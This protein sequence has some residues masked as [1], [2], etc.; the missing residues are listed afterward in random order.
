[1]LLVRPF[2]TSL[3]SQTARDVL[4]VRVVT[5]EAEGWGE[6]VALTDPVY[7]SEYVAGAH[8]VLREYLVPQVLA[9]PLASARQFATR[10][11]SVVGHRMAKAAL[12]TALLD[13]ELRGAS[14]SLANYLGGTREHVD[15]G[16]SVG[17]ASSV[18]ALLDEV[19]Q[20]VARGQHLGTGGAS[21]VPGGV[22]RDAQRDVAP[23]R[24]GG[25]GDDRV[26]A[27]ALLNEHGATAQRCPVRGQRTTQAGARG[28]GLPGLEDDDTVPVGEAQS[29]ASREKVR[30]AAAPEQLPAHVQ[31]AGLVGLQ[32]QPVREQVQRR[33]AGR[34]AEC[35]LE[36]GAEGAAGLRHPQRAEELAGRVHADGRARPEADLR[37][38]IGADHVIGRPQGAEHAPVL[39]EGDEP[40]GN[41]PP[42]DR[43]FAWLVHLPLDA[44]GQH[45]AVGIL[46]GHCT[47][48]P[49]RDVRGE[50]EEVTEGRSVRSVGSRRGPADDGRRP[51]DG[52]EVSPWSGGS[53]KQRD[54]SLLR[55]HGG[56][57]VDGADA[58]QHDAGRA[59]VGSDVHHPGHAVGSDSDRQ[60][61]LSGQGLHVTG[62]VVDADPGDG[63]PQH[64]SRGGQRAQELGPHAREHV[65]HGGCVGRG[66]R[67]PQLP[68]PA[69]V[70][71]PG[72][73]LCQ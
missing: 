14:L 29:G 30:R 2:R 64:A 71:T 51:Q 42:E 20:Y 1:M 28:Y 61:E 31:R 12:E 56:V 3:G 66:G 6:C 4:L 46:D 11:S 25:G 21:G 27:R 48:D 50:G 40:P 47:A 33:R 36:A 5:D 67:G 72:C 17:I 19:S 34:L 15:C 32:L 69:P 16:V 52:G 49:S 57:R 26:D 7:S 39:E 10:T 63:L 62:G 41:G 18:P 22:S 68:T 43:L 55:A 23:G 44:V 35:L 37:N 70:R 53:G 60:D 9:A 8:Q 38:G 54:P 24:R 65:G 58:A 73:G 45:A 59:A 13:A